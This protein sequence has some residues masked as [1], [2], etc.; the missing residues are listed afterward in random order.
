M[1]KDEAEKCVALGLSALKSNDPDKALYLFQKA[2]QLNECESTSKLIQKVKKQI[3]SKKSSESPQYSAENETLCKNICSRTNY[4]EILNISR[5]A[6]QN[7]IKKAYRLLVRQIHPDK[8]NSPSANDAFTKVDKAYKCLS[9]ENKKLH[10]DETGNDEDFGFN[11]ENMFTKD[12]FIIFFVQI[13]ENTIFFPSNNLYK[14]FEKTETE[15]GF[16]E[17]KQKFFPI[18]LVLLLFLV[19]SVGTVKNVYSLDRT[20]QFNVEKITDNLGIQ[21]FLTAE[22]DKNLNLIEKH[23]IDSSVEQAFLAD[24]NKK[25]EKARN[26]KQNLLIRAK[27]SAGF[28]GKVFENYAESLDM[29]ACIRL[30][31]LIST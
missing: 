13:L 9:D 4:Y 22:V 21:Y 27:K 26:K 5:E 1:N 16:F 14:I 31:E 10:Y 29:S 7:D 30:E 2:Q 24:L 17:K 15:A 6:S 11:M 20:S 19:T 28:N 25:C 12:S 23:T 8:N 18:F 3:K